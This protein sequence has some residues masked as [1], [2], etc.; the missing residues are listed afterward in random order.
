MYWGPRDAK[1]AILR[2]HLLV[3]L[4][5]LGQ[6]ADDERDRVGEA[7]RRRQ[8]ELAKA[9][10]GVRVDGDRERRHFGNRRVRVPPEGL[11]NP[12]PNVGDLA[13]AG[14]CH[15]RLLQFGGLLAQVGDL[16]LGERLVERPHLGVHAA[17]GHQHALR[18]IE[19]APAHADL[20][21][22]STLAS[23]RVRVARV[24]DVLGRRLRRERR[25]E[26]HR[27]PAGEHE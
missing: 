15:R 17:A 10:I 24:R 27:H 26:Q 20:H 14:G 1:L 8:S 4:T 22:G 23:G 2:G 3:L 13:A 19:E 6:V 7:E 25:G 18:A 16:A 11:A 21:G 5:E 12:H 9:G